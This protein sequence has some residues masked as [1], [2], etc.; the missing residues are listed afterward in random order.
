MDH[1]KG[2]RKKLGSSAKN[3]FR[4]QKLTDVKNLTE[5]EYWTKVPPTLK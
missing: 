4:Q 1:M 3:D 5:I 2:K